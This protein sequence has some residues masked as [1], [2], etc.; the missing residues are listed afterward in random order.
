MLDD[1]TDN[2]EEDDFVVNLSDQSSW[3]ETIAGH[4]ISL[5]AP[6]LY[7]LIFARCLPTGNHKVD[8]HLDAQFRNPGPNFLSAG[9]TPLPLLYFI[10]FVL[11]SIA[12]VVWCWV[13]SRDEATN[14]T[15]HRVHYMMAIL[16]ALKCLTLLSESIRYHYISIV[17]AAMSEGWSIVYYVFAFFKGVMLFTVILLIG[18][19]WSL[20]KSYLNDREKKIILIVL[21][22]QVLDNIAMVVLEETAQ[23]SQGWL[24]WRDFLHLVDIVCCCAILFPIVWSIRHLRQAAEADGKAQHNLMKLQLFRQFYVMVS[25]CWNVVL[26]CCSIVTYILTFVY[27]FLAGGGIYLFYTHRGISSRS[28]DSFL[29]VVV[30]CH[31]YRT[32]Y[33]VVFC[34]DRIQIQTCQRQSIFTS[35]SRRYRRW[36]IWLGW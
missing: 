6:G 18:S 21:S 15:V 27:C 33:I 19:G 5:S 7:S 16:L 32:S 14:G 8:F 20:M 29:F 4:T 9:D 35:R 26:Y 25:C 34:R 30:R 3:T 22:L 13:L 24:T 10:F 36:R 31:V 23:G 11:F 28:N 12:F 17:G 1:V 2:L